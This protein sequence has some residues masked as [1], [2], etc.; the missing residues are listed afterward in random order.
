[1]KNIHGEHEGHEEE[2]IFF[3]DLG[4]LRGLNKTVSEDPS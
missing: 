1:M 2:L 4:A 3:R